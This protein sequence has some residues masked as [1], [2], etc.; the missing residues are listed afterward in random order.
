MYFGKKNGK[1]KWLFGYRWLK[2]VR[3]AGKVV[4]VES[5]IA[6]VNET[7]VIGKKV[8][9]NMLVGMECVFVLALFCPHIPRPA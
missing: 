3:K 2:A 8:L 4:C 9:K 5:L 1:V 7:E 6:E